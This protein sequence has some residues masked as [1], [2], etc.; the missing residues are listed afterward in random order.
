MY[1]QKQILFNFICGLFLQIYYVNGA[2]LL[3]VKGRNFA[4]FSVSQD[5]HAANVGNLH[6]KGYV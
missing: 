2:A 6:L 1:V 5:I 4:A 3:S